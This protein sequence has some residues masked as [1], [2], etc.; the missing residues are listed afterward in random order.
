ML[1][2]SSADTA[3]ISSQ[4]EVGDWLR[5]YLSREGGHAVASEVIKAAISCGISKRTIQRARKKLGVRDHKDGFA[6]PWVWTLPA[7][8]ASQGAQDASTATVAPLAPSIRGR[9]GEPRHQ[10][11]VVALGGVELGP[12]AGVDPDQPNTPTELTPT[13]GPQSSVDEVALPNDADV[14]D[15]MHQLDTEEADI[16]DEP[17]G[18]AGNPTCLRCG[19]PCFGPK[20]MPTRTCMH[21]QKEDQEA[22]VA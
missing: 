8:G 10:L 22:G 6:G 18:E 16:E 20:T 14:V 1:H 19:R 21:C 9:A 5:E 13:P 2:D 7:Q 12:E 17:T 4:D 3:E 15:T 11:R